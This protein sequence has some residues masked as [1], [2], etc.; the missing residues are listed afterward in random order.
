MTRIAALTC[1]AVLSAAGAVRAE[2]LRDLCPDR[3][4]KGTSACT[5]DKGRWQVEV[6]AIDWTHHKSA[7]VTTDQWTVA[8]PLV[9]YGLTD[10]LDL[11]AGLALYERQRVRGGGASTSA[12]SLGDLYLRAKWHV[13]G[14][15]GQDGLAVEPYLKLPT[16]NHKLG[17]GA[18]E[19]GVL[20]PWQTN[21][22]LGWALDITP[23]V[24][25]L[26]DANG[27]GRHAALTA[28]AGLTHPLTDAVS[29]GLELWTQHNFDPTGG[30]RQY[31]FDLALSWQPK[32]SPVAVDGGVNIGLNRQTPDAELY[33]GISRRF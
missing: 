1:L 6:G 30:T 2:D 8:S 9:K 15:N 23:E 29:L 12:D 20:A 33:V 14:T 13:M 5:V 11:E 19:G 18:V 22:P 24:D 21:L 27:S 28:S 25:V 17:N 10:T 7:G 26:K 31:S 3:P 32:G 4:L 16:A